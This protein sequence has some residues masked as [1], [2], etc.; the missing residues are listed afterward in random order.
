MNIRTKQT[1]AVVLSIGGSV[2]TVVTALL[3]RKA[4]KKKLRLGI[5]YLDLIM[6]L[7]R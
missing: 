5:L 4:A 1:W 2:G 6:N 3:V 7:S